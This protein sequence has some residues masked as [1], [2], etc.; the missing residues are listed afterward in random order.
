MLKFLKHHYHTRYHGIYH[1][2]KKL[3]AFDL[4]LLAS[5]IVLLGA[6][7]FFFFWKPTITDLIDLNF[8]FGNERI[9]SGNPVTIKLEYTNRSKQILNNTILA[10]HLPSGFVIDRAKTPTATLSENF[11]TDIGEIKPG[12]TGQLEIQGTLFAESNID[13]K[14]IAYLTYKPENKS[15]AEQKIGAAMI[16]T[17]GSILQADINLPTST[18]PGREIP[19]T[20]TLKNIGQTRLGNI[21][22]SPEQ[23]KN[24]ASGKLLNGISLEPGETKAIA[25]VVTSPTA[26]G[27]SMQKF[28]FNILINNSTFSLLTLEKKLN[29]IYPKVEAGLQSNYTGAYAD[30]N[31]TIPLRIYWHNASEYKLNNVRI[32]ITPTPGT[33]DLAA[34]ARENNLTV[35]GQTL[36]A[37]KK[38]RTTLGNGTAGA[39]DEFEI[40][41]KLKSFF[42]TDNAS[43]MEIKMKTEAELPDM[44][45]QKLTTESADVI[46]LPLATQISWV[47]KPVYY[48][49]DGDQLGRGPLPP[50]VGETTKY[51]IFVE[52]QNSINAIAKNNFS[53][54]LAD[55]VEF[56]GKESVTLGTQITSDAG[57][58]NWNYNLAPANGKIGLYF[59]VA[60]TPNA[61]QLGKII[62]LVKSASFTAEDDVVG[63]QLSLTNGAV[64]N[65]LLDEDQG[66]AASAKVTN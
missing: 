51:W 40:K 39:S 53:A 7:L 4:I 1:H 38:T 25:G 17:I 28:N 13:Q 50:T 61:S 44:P 64:T 66:S 24:F 34:T 63:K 48:T 57:A 11:T 27:E 14:V 35:D 5:A 37:D 60:V 42:T 32:I 36:V 26:S 62:Q 29:V 9:L 16:K 22:I 23:S 21:T 3:F 15:S 2:A 6:S 30:A 65:E 12:A 41:L 43:Q 59:E 20:L 56:T 18:F 19:A 31:S 54:V 45:G 49:P 55:G 46:R 8:T 52:I 33:V 47:I 58:I 10:V